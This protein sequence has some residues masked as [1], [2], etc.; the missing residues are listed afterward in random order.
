MEVLKAN[1]IRGR[2]TLEL[3]IA[4]RSDQ[5]Q[6]TAL[7]RACTLRK[8][9][10]GIVVPSIAPLSTDELRKMAQLLQPAGS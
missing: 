1:I 9:D 3:R 5:A 4:N 10:I 8:Q 2:L 7:M 6:A